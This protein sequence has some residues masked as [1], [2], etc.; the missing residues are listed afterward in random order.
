[1]IH[2]T[3]RPA[4]YAIA[5]LLLLAWSGSGSAQEDI[6]LSERSTQISSTLPAEI[7]VQSAARIGGLHLAV[8][9]TARETGGGEIV[10]ELRMQM[11][12]DT[13]PVGAQQVIT[14]NDARPFGYVQVIPIAGRFFLFW[15][16]RRSGSAV[17]YMR[18][19]DTGG[20]AGSE[21]IFWTKG[22]TS[23]GIIP[24]TTTRG[25]LLLWSDTT[26]LANIQSRIVKPDGSFNGPPSRFADGVVQGVIDPLSMP[27]KMI[28]DRG[29]RRPLLLD[30]NGDEIPL[31][32]GV[33]KFDRLYTLLADGGVLTVA[34]NVVHLYDTPL[35]SVPSRIVTFPLPNR[36]APGSQIAFLD[37]LRRPGIAYIMIGGTSS[38]PDYVSAELHE[39]TE[40]APGRFGAPRVIGSSVIDR[41]FSHCESISFSPTAT[42]VTRG[43][44]NS[45]LIDL[46]GVRTYEVDCHGTHSST[47]RDMCKKFVTNGAFLAPD[48][49]LPYRYNLDPSAYAY[50]V[51]S[52]RGSTIDV[53]I[54]GRLV[55]LAAPAPSRSGDV[56]QLSPGL[57]SVGGKVAVAWL[58]IGT[59][60][61]AHLGFWNRARARGVD[62]LPDLDLSGVA[63]E[64][65]S[66]T[67]AKSTY[68]IGSSSGRTFAGSSWGWAEFDSTGT[69]YARQRYYLYAPTATGWKL[70]L[71]EDARRPV[72]WLHP[73]GY[74]VDPTTRDL[75]V[76]LATYEATTNVA[77]VMAVI[78]TNGNLVSKMSAALLGQLGTIGF[79]LVGR[80]EF[81]TIGSYQ[82][83]RVKDTTLTRYD[84]EKPSSALY[85]RA[86]DSAFLRSYIGDPI[87][88][89]KFNFESAV[90]GHGAVA[91]PS[92]PY[93]QYILQN[94][95]DSGFAIIYGGNGGVRLVTIDK[96]LRVVDSAR[97]ISAT[98]ENVTRPV[99][100]VVGDS[101]YVAWEDSRSGTPAIYGTVVALHT[102]RSATRREPDDVESAARREKEDR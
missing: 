79:I 29:A 76:F 26:G 18:R 57:Q 12:R 51:P 2:R 32:G 34:N 45:Y 36:V 52:K 72:G 53:V 19:I 98:R 5:L 11:L 6:L 64:I 90:V 89:D 7:K 74:S 94:P 58:A 66:M 68:S 96:D 71:A 78:D 8:W 95:A 75:G 49:T 1:M 20:A 25:T 54:G 65:A 70:A 61:I 56:P 73:L 33:A 88:L 15:N 4:S 23:T 60:T 84:V 59:D 93:H 37:S 13:M 101:L 63:P 46:C 97:V 87:T 92:L 77:H 47:S 48:S 62:T 82:T 22:M 83:I 55:R 17:T 81:I 86:L 21:E 80:N 39:I 42:R 44:G 28:V 3:N 99:A 40:L 43:A 50:R 41:T 24:I 35:D 16:D 38:W 69:A 9:G 100:L 30:A 91:T 10:N 31:G 85:L 14:S 102:R 67:N 27:G